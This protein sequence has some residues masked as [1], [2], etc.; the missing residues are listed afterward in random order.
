MGDSKNSASLQSHKPI[1]MR[2][3]WKLNYS[4]LLSINLQNLICPS[5]SQDHLQLVKGTKARILRAGL[6][7][8]PSSI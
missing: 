2:T 6:K 8:F 1:R 4:I 5:I 3:S 7:T